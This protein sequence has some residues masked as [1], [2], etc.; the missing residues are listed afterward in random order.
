MKQAAIDKSYYKIGDVA[1]L[2]DVPISTLRFWESQFAILSP[3]RNK[4]GT[5]FYTPGD[6]E[7]IRMIRF[8]L[9]D[10]GMRIEAAQEA[11]R[12]NPQGIDTTY[13]V[14][15]RLRAVRTELKAMLD[16]LHTLR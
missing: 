6:V 3:K 8:L 2:T 4:A 1:A 13:R 11:L 14:V 9:Y 12:T 7:H 16:V 5:R 10:K 15:S